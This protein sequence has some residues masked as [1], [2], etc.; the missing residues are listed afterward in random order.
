LA[1]WL[2]R[3]MRIKLTFNASQL[4]EQLASRVAN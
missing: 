3:A 4:V 1:I 2:V